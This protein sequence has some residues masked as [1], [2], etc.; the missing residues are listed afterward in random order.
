MDTLRLVRT[1]R[2]ADYVI[3]DTSHAPPEHIHPAMLIRILPHFFQ[4]FSVIGLQGMQ[5]IFD[6]LAHLI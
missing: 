1:F 3:L 5:I 6:G 4:L 2:T